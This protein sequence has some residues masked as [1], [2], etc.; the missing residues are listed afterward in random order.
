M[1]L[2]YICY[3]HINNL[4]HICY[5]IAGVRTDNLDNKKPFPELLCTTTGSIS[6][7]TENEFQ[8]KSGNPNLPQLNFGMTGFPLNGTVV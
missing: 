3:I 1:L 2:I 6:G 4:S 7:E 5:F 8:Q